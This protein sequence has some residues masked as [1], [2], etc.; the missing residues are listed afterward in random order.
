ML[1]DFPLPTSVF[2]LGTQKTNEPQWSTVVSCLS[3]SQDEFGILVTNFM[4]RV[5]LF[6]I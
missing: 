3:I 2:T 6:M 4:V 1:S 5:N